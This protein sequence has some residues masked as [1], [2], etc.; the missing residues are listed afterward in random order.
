MAF[1]KNNEIRTYADAT[2]VSVRSEEGKPDIIEGY[3]VVFG[4]RSNLLYDWLA[5]ETIIETIE[6]GA[7]TQATIDSL[8]IRATM[9]HDFSQLLARSN[10]GSGSLNLTVDAKGLKYEFVV[11][12]TVD[13]QRASERIRRG[14]LFGSS[15]MFNFDEKTD[16]TYTR[17][18]DN[19]LYRSITNIPFIY[20]VSVVQNPAYSATSVSQRSMEELGVLKNDTEGID[21]VAKKQIEEMRRELDINTKLIF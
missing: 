8:D 15:F 6:P 17:D 2:N 18:K 7:I 3:A 21:S 14:E 16:C 20:D 1:K 19:Q 13:G 11:P 10:K 5:G 12:A 4:A 9:D